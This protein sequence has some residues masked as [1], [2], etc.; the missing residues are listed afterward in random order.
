MPTRRFAIKEFNWSTEWLLMWKWNQLK[1]ARR[2]KFK[3]TVK[4]L[5]TDLIRTVWVCC[6]KIAFPS[7]SCQN[8]KELNFFTECNFWT[9]LIVFK[10]MWKAQVKGVKGEDGVHLSGIERE[11]DKGKRDFLVDIVMDNS[12]TQ[13][14]CFLAS[15]ISSCLR[16]LRGNPQLFLPATAF[17]ETALLGHS[18]K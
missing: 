4:I 18:G 3:N 1:C 7:K 9:G 10:G 12:W 8:L 6:A 16:S 14:L 13:S 11:T 2:L 5:L 17:H 15:S